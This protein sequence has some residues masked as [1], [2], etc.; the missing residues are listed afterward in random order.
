M[1]R[2]TSVILVIIM[3]IS[4]ICLTS[5]DAIE[6][7]FNIYALING[8]GDIEITVPLKPDNSDHAHIYDNDYD[9]CCNICG[10]EREIMCLHESIGIL[11]SKDSTC[12]ENGLTEGKKCIDCGEI[13]VEQKSIPSQAL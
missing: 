2:F 7:I 10:Y 1:K 3:I 4:T 11:D 12:I 13:I 6:L 5:C 8:S 9:D